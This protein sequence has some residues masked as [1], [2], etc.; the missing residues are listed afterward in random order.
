MVTD[1][2]DGQIGNIQLL[3]VKRLN[4]GKRKVAT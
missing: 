3:A 2:A 1:D 4:H